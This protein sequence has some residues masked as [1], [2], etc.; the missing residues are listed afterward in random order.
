M[1]FSRRVFDEVGMFDIDFGAGTWSASSEDSDLLYRVYKKGLKVIYYPDVLVY[2]NHGRRTISQVKSLNKGYAKGR[3]AFY[4]KYI[5][6]GDI[7]VFKLA[8]SEIFSLIKRIIKGAFKGGSSG[9]QR[10]ILTAI[11]T[12]FTGKLIKSNSPLSSKKQKQILFK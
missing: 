6:M 11:L 7:G 1:A 8:Y 5:L 2:H 10:L 12:G 4:C 9:K 3:G